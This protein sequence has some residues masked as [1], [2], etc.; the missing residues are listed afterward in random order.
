M[1]ATAPW[2]RS[3]A[4]V[5]VLLLAIGATVCSSDNPN[6][7]D[8]AT[9]ALDGDP[10]PLPLGVSHHTATPLLDGTLLVA[11]GL[12]S[13][14]AV[15][16]TGRYEPS[17][18]KY[19]PEPSLAAGRFGH[20]ATLLSDGRVLLV[21]GRAGDVVV[22]T[23]EIFVPVTGWE[24]LPGPSGRHSHLAVRLSDERVLV[25]GGIDAEGDALDDAHLFDPLTDTWAVAASMPSPR[26]AAATVRLHDGRVLVAGGSTPLEGAT[27]A[28]FIY[29]SASDSWQP[30]E[31]M[32]VAREGHA[33]VVLHDGRVLVAGGGNGGTLDP[34]A[35]LY[36]PNA[37][38]WS[39]AGSLELARESHGMVVV[40]EGDVIVIGGDGEDGQTG[41]VERWSIDAMEW[42]PFGSLS[43]VRSGHSTVTLPGGSI[44]VLGGTGDGDG[45]ASVEVVRRL[46]GEWTEAARPG[47]ARTEPSLL[48]LP[49]GRVLLFGGAI[50]GLLSTSTQLYDPAADRWST[51]GRLEVA[52]ERH[53]AVLQQE[54]GVLAIGGWDPDSGSLQSVERFDADTLAWSS[55]APL[56]SGRFGHTATLLFDGDVLV[57]G[58]HDGESFV[59][60]SE[61]YAPAMDRWYG[62]ELMGIPH[63]VGHAAV[64]LSSGEV[65]VSGGF[66]E[67]NG[68]LSSVERYDPDGDA[69][70][71]STP[72]GSARQQHSLV[73][74]PDGRVLSVG[75][76]DGEDYLDCSEL[77]DPD[78]ET[79]LP[80]GSMLTA[81][82]QHSTLLLP[83]GLVLV[84]G[85]RNAGGS[86]DDAELFDP[87][88]KSWM[89]AGPMLA[90]RQ[91]HGGALLPSG[92]V[93]VVGG[94]S[95]V[96]ERYEQG[97]TPLEGSRP[98]TT[99]SPS[100]GS[101][102]GLIEWNRSIVGPTGLGGRTGDGQ[103]DVPNLVLVSLSGGPPVR[104]SLAQF[105]PG[106]ATVVMPSSVAA[107]WYLA[108]LSEGGTIGYAHPVV[109]REPEGV[110]ARL[111]FDTPETV[112]P[113]GRCSVEVRASIRDGDDRRVSVD[114]SVAVEVMLE[115]PEASL[116]SDASCVEP[117]TEPFVEAGRNSLGFFFRAEEEGNLRLS[118]LADDLQSD[119]QEHRVVR[120]ED[121]M[122]D[123]VILS[124]TS[125]VGRVGEELLLEA[126]V[127]GADGR[128]L[129]ETVTITL[130]V[131]GH[132][133]FVGPDQSSIEVTTDASTGRARVGVT[134]DREEPLRVV[135]VAAFNEAGELVTG[136]E[137]H[138]AVE[139]L[140]GYP[141]EIVSEPTL[142]GVVGEAY[143]YGDTGRMEA[144]GTSSISYAVHAGP[145]GISVD[146][147]SGLVAWVPSAVRT[148]EV[149]LTASSVFGIDM[150]SFVVDVIDDDEAAEPRILP[151]ALSR[152]MVGTPYP[153]DEDGRASAVGLRP[154]VWEKVE[155]PAEFAI[156]G[157]TGIVAWTPERAALETITIA[158]TN[159]VGRDEYTFTV[160]VIDLDDVHQP[161][162]VFATISP[163]SGESPL[164]VRGDATA[165]Q[166]SEGSEIAFFRW[167]LGDGSID[168]FGP[169]FEHVYAVPGSY[170]VRVEVT[171][172]F[173][174]VG[175]DDIIV[176]VMQDGLMPPRARVW[177]SVT[178][179]EDSLSASF[180]CDCEPGSSP[181]ASYRWDFGDGEVSD[182]PSPTHVFGPGSHQ[183]RLLL[184]DEEGLT[185]RDTVTVRVSDGENLPPIVS[186]SGAPL[187][188]PAPLQV[189]LLAAFVD[190]DG[191]VTEVRWLFEDGSSLEGHSQ[192]HT[193]EEPGLW[194]AT[195][196]V[197][198]DQ[199]LA[200]RASLEVTVTTPDGAIP[201]SIVSTP[202][203]TAEVGEPYRYNREGRVA[204]RGDRP[205]SFSLGKQVGD[206]LEGVPEGMRVDPVTGELTWTPNSEQ[207]GS[208]AVALVARNDAGAALQEWTIDV[209]G[210]T[211]EDDSGTGCGCGASRASGSA[212]AMLLLLLFV[213]CRRSPVR[214]KP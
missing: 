44:L 133:R 97:I 162:N 116:F 70:R 13:E 184:T 164:R 118:V 174:A 173:G 203:R 206:R 89:P 145:A 61:L 6:T 190:P 110:P 136:V 147:E 24:P 158:A 31:A 124:S 46:A 90:A 2:R 48:S 14:G 8:R 29:D 183:V 107:G 127:V 87:L 171:D 135:V 213:A 39:D 33:A 115:G 106:L 211:E 180:F 69:W 161:P 188:G 169:L 21:G 76:F 95:E 72:M 23:H 83:S 32:P 26:A 167:Q 80:A 57:V 119:E 35:F 50:G 126:Q 194:M 186:V 47:G 176:S 11:G 141:P 189:N 1:T 100:D 99:W 139:I 181:L 62:R 117:L 160:E 74:L 85:G 7:L 54:G 204:A 101:G 202:G 175:T 68:Y 96:V 55:M 209:V 12:S 53:A 191:E 92:E 114:E 196:E 159:E 123:H 156:D 75:G 151:T 132:G 153:Y 52:R 208:E 93:L 122:P 84:T 56:E 130:A 199:G 81:R 195:A 205:I 142:M 200:S 103:A 45:Q 27:A 4:L 179:G 19:H 150:Q 91:G 78:T 105:S 212:L 28:S 111:A 168:R 214:P 41:T 5:V 36:D 77:Y 121:G 71:D 73:A 17:S 157:Q 82:A 193:F 43:E 125:N 9:S 192:T 131:D 63:R 108:F 60:A 16:E 166:P 172:V 149:V 140:F 64:L 137:G 66:Q 185:A 155:G 128:L 177:A 59:A 34:T 102:E 49:D 42:E 129:A 152:A 144:T 86:V 98:Q 138:G 163:Q 120:L 22:D 198:D 170:V 37:D 182:E 15:S 40:P 67:E 154:I 79:W 109:V 187:F 51:A 94:Y 148:S 134:T 113:V 30:M 207:V 58:G 143:L 65:L 112:S 146:P 165:S 178:E 25:A 88:T 38:V 20:S 210:P 3:M 18:G 197:L 201:P 104:P 10:P